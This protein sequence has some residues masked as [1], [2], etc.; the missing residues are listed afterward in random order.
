MTSLQNYKNQQRTRINYRHI[1]WTRNILLLIV[2]F[3]VVGIAVFAWATSQNDSSISTHSGIIFSALFIISGGSFL[4]TFIIGFL[5][6]IPRSTQAENTNPKISS[7]DGQTSEFKNNT[8]N[9]RLQTN[10]N[11]QEIS[12]WLTKMIVGIGLTQLYR[13]PSLLAA[14]SNFLSEGFTD[15]QAMPTVIA[16]SIVFFGSCGF[17]SGYLM[18]RLF[19]AS[20]FALAD[21]LLD[22]EEYSIK[23]EE[24]GQN[25]DSLNNKEVELLDTILQSNAKGENHIISV[26]D[27]NNLDNLGSLMKKSLVFVSKIGPSQQLGVELTPIVIDNEEKIRETIKKVIDNKEKN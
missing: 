3:G 20:A 9:Q 25:L 12:D 21:E 7:R 17:L 13:V 10:T 27:K 5:F 11:L 14:L 23:S 1:K 6:G 19:L 24:L 26:D 4:S 15:N 16:S 22:A 18:T 2:F 8:Q